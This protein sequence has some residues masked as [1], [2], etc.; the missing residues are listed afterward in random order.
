MAASNH[1]HHRPHDDCALVNEPEPGAINEEL[2]V[3]EARCLLEAS[4]QARSPPSSGNA[5]RS[6]AAVSVVARTCPVA[7][8]ESPAAAIATSDGIPD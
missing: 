4:S 1:Y 3:N 7:A 6:S 2:V 5:K 8:A